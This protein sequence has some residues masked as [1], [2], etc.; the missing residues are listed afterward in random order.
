M[1]GVGGGRAAPLKLVLSVKALNWRQNDDGA[2]EADR[3]FEHA[4]RRALERDDHACRFCGFRAAKWQEVHHLNDDHA[5]NRLENLATTCL[6]CHMCQHIGRAGAVGEATLVWLP[7]IPQDRLNNLVKACLVAQR[8]TEM[9][10][11]GQNKVG[12]HQQ[13]A[14]KYAAE[15]A[16]AFFARV[17]AREAEAERRIG[18]SSAALLGEV[19]A[20]I[21]RQSSEAYGHRDR[22]LQG[23]RLL[24]TGRRIS[25]GV[26]IMPTILDAW[27]APGSGPYGN[28]PVTT[29]AQL[30][31]SATRR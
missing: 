22:M 13:Q 7:E 16:K 4:R 26:D 18:T 1:S 25:N 28:I 24:P 3:E 20:D 6:H 17:Q 14:A 12:L 27:S 8:Q 29:W 23:I 19:L 31:L 2:E 10:L 9:M 21:A 5:D 15:A 11:Q 30:A